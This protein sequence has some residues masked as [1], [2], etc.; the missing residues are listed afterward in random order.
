MVVPI[1][2]KNLPFL[3]G[4]LLLIPL[5]ADAQEFISFNQERLEI[6]RKGMIVLGSW[7]AGN[8]IVSAWQ[9]TQTEGQ[10]RY[11]HQMNVFWNVVNAGIAGFGYYQSA[12]GATDLS[13]IESMNEQNSIEKILLFN[14][15]LDVAYIATGLY[16]KERG[17]VKSEKFDQF[18][19]YGN[20]L[21]LQGGFLLV[22]DIV[23]H[24]L[25]VQHKAH[26]LADI[27]LHVSPAR[28]SMVL[29]F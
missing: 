20:S 17:K 12:N 28:Y 2:M 15:G 22:F 9:Y 8:M 13:L 18:T 4:A 23:M 29:P 19:G 1:Y 7:A 26:W 14:A 16:L 3:I 24:Q 25:H 10:T 6:N 11:F 21:I 27:Q 5:L